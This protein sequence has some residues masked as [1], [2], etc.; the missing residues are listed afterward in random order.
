MD[1]HAFT[2]ADCFRLLTPFVLLSAVCR[3]DPSRPTGIE[4]V[5]GDENFVSF[6]YV[7]TVGDQIVFETTGDL[8]QSLYP[9]SSP[10]GKS[11][12]SVLFLLIRTTAFSKSIFLGH[13]RGH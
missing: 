12:S 3:F 6:Q 11:F 4:W 5:N 7:I 2:N 10:V 8:T 1:R 13:T 9:F